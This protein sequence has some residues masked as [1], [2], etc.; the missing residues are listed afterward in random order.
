MRTHNFYDIR[1]TLGAF[2]SML[3]AIEFILAAVAKDKLPSRITPI[4]H[5][6]GQT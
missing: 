2:K 5:D 1:L 4:R 3:I 6:A